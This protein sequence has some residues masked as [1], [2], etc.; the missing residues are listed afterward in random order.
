[1]SKFACLDEYSRT[2]LLRL[3]IFRY[4]PEW[5]SSQT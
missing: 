2:N 1:M 3:S 4:H 5:G